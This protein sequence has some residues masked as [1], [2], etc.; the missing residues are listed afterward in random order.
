M[1]EI[2]Q[3]LQD[4]EDAAQIA[5]LDF[6]QLTEADFDA[7][8]LDDDGNSY[9]MVMG[10][11]VA[12]N[13]PPPQ[14]EG[15]IKRDVARG[16]T[17]GAQQ[18]GEAL[19]EF[20]PMLGK[21]VDLVNEGLREVGDIFGVD[22]ASDNPVGGSAMIR[23]GVQ[24]VINFG[25]RLLPRGV[26][27]AY[28]EFVNEP[29]RSPIVQSIVEEVSKF[30]VQA[31]TP[32]MYLRA[33]S[34]M[35]PFA[36]G[37]AWGG[38][39][40]FI[41]A[42][43]DDT[44]AIQSVTELLSSSS[45]QERG[46]VA[47]AV[48]QVIAQNENDPEIV[49]RARM[50]LDGMVVGGAI[51]K[52]A[53]L[54]IK[55]ARAVPLGDVARA[56]GG[57][58]MTAARGVNQALDY[59]VDMMGGGRTL[60]M[61][62]GPVPPDPMDLRNKPDAMGFRSGVYNMLDELPNAASGA[63]ILATLRDPQRLGKYGAK[64]E[65][66][67]LL[68]LPEFLDG[69]ERVTKEDLKSFVEENRIEMEYEASGQKNVIGEPYEYSSSGDFEDLIANYG[70]SE[71]GELVFGISEVRAY[72]PD[73]D[74]L[75]EGVNIE[76][77]FNFNLENIE[78]LLRDLELTVDSMEAYQ[79]F[80]RDP[81]FDPDIAE[82]LT[83]E[84]GANYVLPEIAEPLAEA[85]KIFADA[86][87]DEYQLERQKDKLLDILG[88]IDDN[89]G[90]AVYSGM[91]SLA[92]Y[93]VYDQYGRVGY[94][95]TS[96]ERAVE[97]AN[98]S[99]DGNTSSN[100]SAYTFPSP[101]LQ[102]YQE[103][104]VLMPRSDERFPDKLNV[105]QHFEENT[106]SFFR[107]TDRDINLEGGDSPVRARFVEEIQSD[108]AQQANKKGIIPKGGEQKARDAFRAAEKKAVAHQDTFVH[109]PVVDALLD[110][111]ARLLP[112]RF[113]SDADK[114]R[115]ANRVFDTIYEAIATQR[116]GGI[117]RAFVSEEMPGLDESVS[118][119]DSVASRAID[120]LNLPREVGRLPYTLEDK[121]RITTAVYEMLRNLTPEQRADFNQVID[122]YK[123]TQ[124]Y[125]SGVPDFPMRKNW[126][127]VT[128]KAAIADAVENGHSV[129]AFPNSRAT[130]AEIENYGAPRDDAITRL[131][132]KD[133]PKVLKKLARQYDGTIEVGRLSD[134]D[135]ASTRI[136]DSGSVIV[137]RLN[138]PQKVRGEGI[139]LPS[140]IGGGTAATGAAM[141]NDNQPASERV[142]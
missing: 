23:D 83:G 3:N 20:L 75:D 121:A 7:V 118:T 115:I 27:D 66:I 117:P 49:N 106:F 17:R 38:I 43:P 12:I 54:L 119:L 126:V 120:A 34:V 63:Q 2:E 128:A 14:E 139:A 32:A 39:A 58:A 94:E 19:N 84:R 134:A 15:S 122:T 132:E 46:A 82:R 64:A 98:E 86:G 25:D 108:A 141:Q 127:E 74:A 11:P 16:V 72:A 51:E 109:K 71:T 40:D 31:V 90:G 105:S 78:F 36:R 18:A 5:Q 123:T 33:F 70:G 24:A 42:Q 100:N 61:G 67:E 107:S 35:S 28:A 111:E 22:L 114:V 8:E 77:V 69:K 30:G 47:N 81:E 95:G 87:D 101:L 99:L 93:R 45:E 56:V 55:T 137:L 135:R 60:G 85:K 97:D 104:R 79:V 91:E 110:L 21:P 103:F 113:Q 48:L 131:Y 59:G 1:N 29:P 140:V 26:N 13:Q 62:V 129:I 9:G 89:T 92:E 4:Y 68:G 125:I 76:Q 136:E 44:S 52:G 50:A 73:G 96:Y 102:N 116:V 6:S 142:F 53:E 112:D 80:P 65:E 138:D 10:V 37:L 41:N 133:L 88:H 130:V 124:S 57:G